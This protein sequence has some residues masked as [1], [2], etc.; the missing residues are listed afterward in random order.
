[1]LLTLKG[2]PKIIKGNFY[3]NNNKLELLEYGPNE[4][5][6]DYSCSNNK[7]TTLKGSPNIVKG[8][9]NC[10]YNQLKSLDYGPEKVY[11]DYY[12]NNNNIKTFKGFPKKLGGKFICDGNPIYN[13]WKLFKNKNL[14]DFFNEFE[15]IS[16]DGEEV[17]LFRLNMFLGDIRIDKRVDKIEGYKCV[18]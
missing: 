14:V 5:Y 10:S 7:L 4:V 6:N 8:I 1:M 2:S 17:S 12:C 9:F 18:K 13:I 15:V 11:K 16:K 3:C